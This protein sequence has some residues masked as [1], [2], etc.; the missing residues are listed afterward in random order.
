M[1]TLGAL[2][3][4]LALT[5]CAGEA[6]S[7][8]ASPS[9]AAATSQTPTPGPLEPTT[10]PPAPLGE[11]TFLALGDSLTTGFASCETVV[12]CEAVSWALGSDPEVDSIASRLAEAGFAVVPVPAAREGI[13][14]SGGAALLDEALATP[15]APAAADLDL[16]TVMF[17][18]NDVCGDSAAEMTTPQAFEHSLTGLLDQLSAAAPEADV[19]VLSIPNLTGVYEAGRHDPTASER[20]KLGQCGTILGGDDAVRAQA[21]TRLQELNAVIAA[22]CSTSATCHTDD[23]AIAA[24]DVTLEWLSPVDYF[25]PSTQGQTLLAQAAWPSVATALGLEQEAGT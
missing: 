15:G 2:L 7:P 17:G 9:S 4:A 20:W 5:A 1:R 10:P 11:L 21:A 14:M 8:E 22:T 13:T 24:S 18:A 12:A 25:H 3:A 23:G 16:V 6:K 19:L